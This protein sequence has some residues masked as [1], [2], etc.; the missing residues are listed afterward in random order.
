MLATIAF[1]LLALAQAGPSIKDQ[2]KCVVDGGEA[3]SD[4]M[5]ASI[6]IWGAKQRCTQQDNQ[7]KC[8]IDIASAVQSIMSMTNT[9]L[10]V[11][12]RCGHHFDPDCGRAS[13]RLVKAIAEMASANGGIKQKCHNEWKQPVAGG[14]M[15]GGNLPGTDWM[16]GASA[17]C[18]L[19]VKNTAKNLL[20]TVKSLV[21]IDKKC[22]DPHSRKCSSH[23]LK[24]VGAMAGLGEYVA[25]LIGDCAPASQMSHDAECA[26]ESIMLTHAVV[27]VAEAGVEIS[28]KCH[29]KEKEREVDPPVIVEVPVPRLYETDSSKSSASNAGFANIV[30]GAFLPVTAIVSFVAG[31]FYASNRARGEQTREFMSDNE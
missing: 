6:F 11:V 4:L 26:Q 13:T 15:V 10:K 12:G 8:E 1:S 21:K 24:V 14:A 31:R 5:D 22:K 3:A 29:P 9:I 17:L 7:V 2:A 16:H 20:K 28:K 19:D 27:R 30:L 18:V 25:A 23:A